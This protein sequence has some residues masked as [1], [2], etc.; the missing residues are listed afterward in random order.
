MKKISIT[1]IFLLLV[2][3]TFSDK[4]IT[5]GPNPGEIYFRGATYTDMCI[6]Y[7]TDHGMTAICVDSTLYE[8]YA[9]TAGITP[10][11]LYYVSLGGGLYISYSYG[12]EGSWIYRDFML[13]TKINSG[14][15]IGHIYRSINK[16]SEDFGITFM[17]HSNNG[18][19]GSVMDVELDNQEN[20]GYIMVSKWAVYDTIYLVKTED[21]FENLFIQRKFNT[22]ATDYLKIS[23]GTKEG[24]L[25][26][27]NRDHQDLYFSDDFGITWVKQNTMNTTHKFDDITG[28]RQDG[29]IYMTLRFNSMG[30]QN[31]QI[32]VLHSMDYGITFD[33]HCPF[34]KGQQPLSANFSAKTSGEISYRNSDDPTID[35]VYYV[36]GDMPLEVE[37]CNFSIGDI[38][39]SE[40]DFDNNG[41]VDSHEEHP[42][43]TYSDTGW[44]SVKLT[45]HD[46]VGS[47]SFIKENYI[48]VYNI[49]DVE[50]HTSENQPALE[51]FPNPFSDQIKF[52]IGNTGKTASRKI[53]IYN[54]NGKLV[55]QIST[56]TDIAAW[57]GTNT[58]GAKCQ[59]GIYLVRMDTGDTVNKIL[60][61]Q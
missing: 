28:G 42:V 43:Y 9:I 10:G 18:F 19:F 60:L 17:N 51:C 21:N 40:W 27:L 16:H 15:Q 44:Y 20:V 41:I 13:G 50:E 8:E 31:A 46:G 52:V 32:Y 25:Y 3:N 55:K 6:Y 1:A 2:I 34:T 59:P 12:Y 36:T 49:T 37:F 22:G 29:E 56:N 48:Y 61:T 38:L 47:N 30:W 58:S 45:V 35:S 33:V 57:N 23:R 39:Q 14:L 5:R 7:S 53:S 54:M 11:V 24:E 4:F 26:Y